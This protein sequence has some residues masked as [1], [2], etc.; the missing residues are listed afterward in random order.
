MGLLLGAD[1]LDMNF[2]KA[3][4]GFKPNGSASER[5]YIY[6]A[7]SSL[8]RKAIESLLYKLIGDKALM[9]PHAKTFT[10]FD[11]KVHEVAMKSDRRETCC[12]MHKE[13]ESC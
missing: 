5:S 11:T 12:C 4:Y 8:T 6:Y 7:S 13:A 2:I 9:L 3:I 1:T 10:M